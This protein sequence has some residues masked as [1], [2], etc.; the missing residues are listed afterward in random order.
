MS[1]GTSG[2]PWVRGGG[3][4]LHTFMSAVTEELGANQ[5]RTTRSQ[6]HPAHPKEVCGRF[7]MTEMDRRWAEGE[8]GGA[9]SGAYF[10]G[11]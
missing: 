8:V 1:Q 11:T 5:R 2:R 6:F 9:F 7:F 4:T 10:F 3:W